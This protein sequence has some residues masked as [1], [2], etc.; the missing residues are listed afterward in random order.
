MVLFPAFADILRMRT[1]LQPDDI[2]PPCAHDGCEAA[3]NREAAAYWI[4]HAGYDTEVVSGGEPPS[5]PEHRHSADRR[6][7]AVAPLHRQADEGEGAFAQQRFQ[8][9]Q[10]FDVGDVELKARLVYE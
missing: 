10:A 6:S 3:I 5:Q 9:A 1:L 8:I 2:T 7:C 4:P